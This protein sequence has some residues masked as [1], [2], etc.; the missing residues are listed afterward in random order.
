M[1]FLRLS[2][3]AIAGLV[4]SLCG[5]V[6]AQSSYPDKPLRIVSPFAAG[7]TTDVIARIVAQKLAEGFGQPV[8]VDPR[9]GANGIVAAEHVAKSAPDGYTII[10]ASNGT[11]GINSS[12]FAKLPYDPVKDFAPITRL[13]YTGYLLVVNSTSPVSSVGDLVARAKANP[14][15]HSLAYT[16]SV[17][18]LTGALFMLTTG[19]NMIPVPYKTPTQAFTDLI[20][21][22]VDA[23]IEPI[24]SAL[25]QVKGGRL[26]ALAVTS[27][28]RS[29]LAPDI[30]TFAESG[31][32]GFEVTGSLAM[33]GIDIV[34]VPYKGAGPAVADLVAGQVQM[35]IGD[36]LTAGPQIKA[37]KLRVLAVS[38][39]KRVQAWP[40]LPTIAEAGVPGY[41]AS[42]WL[43]M[44]AP[45]GTPPEV[46][47]KLHSEI[48]WALRT[49]EIRDRITG[50]GGEPMGS[51][52]L[53]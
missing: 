51:L 42:G 41:E 32:T 26:K 9:P 24:T 37:G 52:G 22:N 25:P 16:A 44:F 34:H 50:S 40:D 17:A 4:A 8:I 10:I 28:R 21:G 6:L 49:P 31:Y 11:H 14:G 47:G 2:I 20:G 48:V 33:T 3:I 45:G 5:P 23:L 38:S 7:G 15:R 1:H 53:W 29:S 39:S 13:G 46:V 43:G 36:L 19:I 18:Q 12:L 30:P 27:T 35:T